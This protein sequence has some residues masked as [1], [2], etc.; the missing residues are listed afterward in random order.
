MP[1]DFAAINGEP[2]RYLAESSAK[3]ITRAGIQAFKFLSPLNLLLHSQL[4][5]LNHFTKHF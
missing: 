4:K 2:I 1:A 5:T 3:P